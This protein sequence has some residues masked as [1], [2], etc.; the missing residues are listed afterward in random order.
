MTQCHDGP[1]GCSSSHRPSTD[2]PRRPVDGGVFFA[3][4][5]SRRTPI[6]R[7]DRPLEARPARRM[8]WARRDVPRRVLFLFAASLFPARLGAPLDFDLLYQNRGQAL[9]DRSVCAAGLSLSRAPPSVECRQPIVG[10]E[11]QAKTKS[12]I[13]LPR[14]FLIIIFAFSQNRTMSKTIETQLFQ[15]HRTAG[16]ARWHPGRPR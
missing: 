14:S 11:M 7:I 8:K 10:A 15:T 2:E 13:A 3:S 16:R 6:P 12:N 5:F 1:A 9:M 4:V